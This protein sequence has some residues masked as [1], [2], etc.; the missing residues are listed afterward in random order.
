MWEG[1]INDEGRI[2]YIHLGNK[3]VLMDMG[4]F[5]PGFGEYIEGRSTHEGIVSCVH[6]RKK[7][8]QMDSGDAYHPYSHILL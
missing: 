6:L 8:A 5:L 4:V 1:R 3:L 7:L 2:I